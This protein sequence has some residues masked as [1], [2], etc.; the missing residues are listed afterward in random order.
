VLVEHAVD[1]RLQLA[2]DHAQARLGWRSTALNGVVDGGVMVEATGRSNERDEQVVTQTQIDV[3]SVIACTQIKD[4]PVITQTQTDNESVIARIQIDDEWV[5]ASN[6]EPA[7][8]PSPMGAV[9]AMTPTDGSWGSHS[10]S[11]RTAPWEASFQALTA[12]EQSAMTDCRGRHLGSVATTSKAFVLP[13][14]GVP[15]LAKLKCST[16]FKSFTWPLPYSC[17]PL[18]VVISTSELTGIN[19]IVMLS[20]VVITHH[21]FQCVSL[22]IRRMLIRLAIA[23]RQP[24]EYL[25]HSL[26]LMYLKKH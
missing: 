10:T 25:K 20:Q 7:I 2:W 8:S 21:C 5:I 15:F 16:L 1:R 22:L 17:R 9:P 23:C 18:G 14:L 24:E 6:N 13:A 19:I 3:K 11:D 12:H 4:E 26:C